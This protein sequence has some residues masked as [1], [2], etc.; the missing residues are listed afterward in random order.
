MT[1]QTV[2]AH[3]PLQEKRYTPEECLELEEKADYRSE[4]DDDIITLMTGGTTDHNQ[5][6][7]N[8]YL[9][10]SIGFKSQNFRVSFGDV[11]L[12]IPKIQSFK[13]PRVDECR[14]IDPNDG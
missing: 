4:Y 14:T 3:E 13:Y 9:A 8:C 12:W 10:L 6:V 5:I 1:T 7:G 2:L 11:R